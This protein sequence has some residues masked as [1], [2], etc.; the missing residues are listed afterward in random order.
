MI[1]SRVL[2]AGALRAIDSFTTLLRACVRGGDP[3]RP[4]R[5]FS[6]NNGS[7]IAH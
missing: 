1:G 3:A 7:M 6:S 5:R 2:A 4:P